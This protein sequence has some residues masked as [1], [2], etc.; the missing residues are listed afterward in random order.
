M[1]GES[2]QEGAPGLLSGRGPDVHLRPA[3]PLLQ[4]VRL[5][6]LQRVLGSLRG[7]GPSFL[8][9]AQHPMTHHPQQPLHLTLRGRRQR[10]EAHAALPRHEDAVRHQRVE[11]RRHLQGGA[12]ELDERHG[13][14]LPTPQAL[15]PCPS[16]LKGKHRAQ[17][18]GEDVR[19]QSHVLEQHPPDP[20]R[21]GQRP[22]PVGHVRQHPL[23]QMHRR[24]MRPLRVA[25]RA[26]P[27]ALTREGDEQLVLATLAA[28]PREA[29]RQ[30]SA[31]QV[32]GEVPLHVPGQAAPYLAG[33][34]QQCGQVVPHRLVQHRPLRLPSPVHPPV[35]PHL[36][37]PSHTSPGHTLP[38]A[39][40]R[41]SRS[42][43][44]LVGGEA[45]ESRRRRRVAARA[46]LPAS[47]AARADATCFATLLQQT[48][49][50]ALS[51]HVGA[52]QRAA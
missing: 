24:H 4:G 43:C 40:H 36:P 1:Q 30:H 35:R 44:L 11:V 37:L 3:Q 18:D 41:S 12:E 46:G 28:H 47:R 8:Q 48:R 16:A 38:S 22:L 42:P 52:E 21:K 39:S 5:V 13:P 15:P 26:H 9:Q 27:S 45:Y 20:M 19:E 49:A 31:F 10:L 32:L 14:D 51:T 34:R 50:G 23:H 29:V 2:F 7:Q 33:L 17:E 25:G 6:R